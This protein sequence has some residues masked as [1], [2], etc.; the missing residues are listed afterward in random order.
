MLSMVRQRQR[1]VNNRGADAEAFSALV[2]Q[3]FK[4]ARALEAA[5][6]ALAQPAGQSAAR[7][8]VLAAAEHAP[9]TVASI[10]R[11]LSHTRQSVQ[12]VADLLAGEGLARYRHNPAHQR[13]KLLELTPPGLAALRTIQAAQAE[14]ARRIAAGLDPDRLDAA[15]LT[16]AE[17]EAR[18]PA[19]PARGH[20]GEGAGP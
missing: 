15:R 10:A 2:V 18:L 8:Q 3:V 11:T 9:A 1:A 4:L 19:G 7:W 13:A 6:N 5:G 20:G 17:L 16:L 12:R 14:W